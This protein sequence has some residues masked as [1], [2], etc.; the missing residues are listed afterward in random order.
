MEANRDYLRDHGVEALIRHLAEEAPE[1]EEQDVFRSV[2]KWYEKEGKLLSG[3]DMQCYN[4]K[5]TM[6]CKYIHSAHHLER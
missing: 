4:I 6:I 5:D 2:A 1:L 3:Y